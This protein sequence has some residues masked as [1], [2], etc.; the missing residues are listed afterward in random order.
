MTN[1]IYYIGSEE[2]LLKIDAVIS[3]VCGFPNLQGTLRWATPQK[4]Y[5]QDF[6]FLPKPSAE[7]Y[8]LG[9]FSHAQMV[10]NI[11]MTNVTELEWNKDWFQPAE[12]E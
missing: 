12:D 3:E 1:S 9:E 4:V 6:Y 2:D 11:D 8:N 7:G 5:N 10:A